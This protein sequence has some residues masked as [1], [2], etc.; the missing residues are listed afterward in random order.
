MAIRCMRIAYSVPKATNTLS[1]YVIPIAL[2]AIMVARTRL[3]VTLYAHGLPF[4]FLLSVLC[5]T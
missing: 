4:Q 2:P 5:L 3:I 1:E